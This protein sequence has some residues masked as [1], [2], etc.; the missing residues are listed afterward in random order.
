MYKA[1]SDLIVLRQSWAGGDIAEDGDKCL[2]LSIKCAIS[3]KSH[4][5]TCLSDHQAFQV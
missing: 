4:T 5:A 1:V 2:D 3:L